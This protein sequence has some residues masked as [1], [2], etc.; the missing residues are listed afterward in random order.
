MRS[1]GLR[2]L[3]GAALLSVAMATPALADGLSGTA[4]A[5][6]DY[7]FRGITQTLD[8]PTVQASIG[9]DF[10]NGFSVGAWGSGIDFGDGKSSLETDYSATYSTT[11]DGIGISAGG[12]YYAY[13][14]SHSSWNYNYFEGWVGLSKDFGMFSVNG[15]VYYSPE[16]F[17]LSSAGDAWYVQGGVGVPITSW[18]S[19]A[20]NYGY[21][22][23]NSTSY[24]GPGRKDYSNWNLGLTGTYKAYALNVMY[25]QTDLPGSAGDAKVV[26][27][28]SAS[29]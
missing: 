27:M 22:T 28:L 6:T 13:P 16:F 2:T 26:V 11:L 1:I 17:G 3:V 23:V 9:Y 8:K 5:T 18:L 24:F 21:Q 12:I 20:G 25:S 29:F 7:L 14:T 19:A 10:G 15:S 4:A